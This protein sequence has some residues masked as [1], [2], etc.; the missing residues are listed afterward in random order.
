[1]SYEDIRSIA[2]MAGLFIFI[3]LFA[4]VLV[5]SFWPGN[6]RR[7]ERASRIPLEKDDSAGGTDGR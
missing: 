3:A 5:Y 1:M 4:G 2:A 7:F 6:E